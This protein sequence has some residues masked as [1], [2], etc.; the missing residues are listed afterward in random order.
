MKS[1]TWNDTNGAFWW[2]RIS[3][4]GNCQ[5]HDPSHTL[6]L[7]LSSLCHTWIFRYH[8]NN[9]IR[10]GW[11][12]QLRWHVLLVPGDVYFLIHPEY[13]CLVM[14]TSFYQPFRPD[15]PKCVTSRQVTNALQSLLGSPLTTPKEKAAAAGTADDIYL[16]TLSA[17]FSKPP[18]EEGFTC[19]WR[20]DSQLECWM[21]LGRGGGVEWWETSMPPHNPSMLDIKWWDQTSPGARPWR[22]PWPASQLSPSSGTWV[23]PHPYRQAGQAHYWA[24]SSSTT[25]PPPN[26]ASDTNSCTRHNGHRHPQSYSR[27]PTA[28]HFSPV[29]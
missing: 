8:L 13:W 5:F 7:L 11:S 17:S 19:I 2:S 25:P 4:Y 15:R 3:M 23:G 29:W 22:R 21:L 20:S 6:P 28:V 24:L 14:F 10:L 1:V 27:M 9:E 16:L 18:G 12:R 26:P